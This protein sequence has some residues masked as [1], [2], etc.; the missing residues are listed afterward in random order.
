MLRDLK[1]VRSMTMKPSRVWSVHPPGVDRD[2]AHKQA[3]G[4][5]RYRQPHAGYSATGGASGGSVLA[6]GCVPLFLTDGFKTY[7]TALLSHFG[8]WVQPDVART[9]ARYPSSAGCPSLSC[10]M[11]KLSRHTGVRACGRH[12]PRGVRH[13]A[14]HRAGLSEMWLEDQY[15]VCRA[16]QS[17]HPPARRRDRPPG[18]YPLS[19]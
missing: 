5:G 18:Q 6:P 16:A 13:H 10:S 7:P 9:Q 19:G 4:G 17:R 2:G 1:A 11:R 14:S 12:T 3:P 8:L 15:G